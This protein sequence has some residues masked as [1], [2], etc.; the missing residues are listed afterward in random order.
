MNEKLKQFQKLLKK[1]NIQAFC[2]LDN[3]SIRYL[4][5]FFFYSSGDAYL[6]ITQTKA[7][8]FTKKMYA[9]DLK[10]KAPYLTLVDSLDIEDVCKKASKFKNKAFDSTLAPYI[11]GTTLAE[12]GFKTLPN[13]LEQA[14]DVK[15]QSELKLITK[16]CHISASAFKIFQK[17]LKAGMTEKQGAAL[18]ESIMQKLGGQGLAF[19]TILAFGENTANPH[20][21]NSDRKLKQNEPVLVDFGCRYKGYCSDITR[22]WWYGSKVSK[23]WQKLFDLMKD[24]HDY[25]A[26]LA[27]DKVKATTLDNAAR[28]FMDKAGSY[29][30]AFIHS[31]GHGLGLKI[32]QKPYLSPKSQDLLKNNS[33]FTIEPGVY[34]D[35]KFGIRYEDTFV[36][37]PKGAKILTK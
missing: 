8:C 4:T 3:D 15:T 2:V 17:Q 35:G 28:D 32:H 20:H 24:T 14:Q 13:F 18:L 25:C 7:Y 5:D 1:E 29:S 10:R 21:H 31:L 34:Y 23:E 9:G 36:L 12:S 33:V 22:S 30:K 19:D 26:T 6:L 27:K 11:Q 16:A 37:T